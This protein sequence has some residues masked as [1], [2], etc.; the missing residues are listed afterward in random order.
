[1][2]HIFLGQENGPPIIHPINIP[3]PNTDVVY[4]VSPEG[5]CQSQATQTWDLPNGEKLKAQSMSGYWLVTLSRGN[6]ELDRAE[7]TTHQLH[8]S[9]VKLLCTGC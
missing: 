2:A 6:T 3:R 4:A 5:K 7:L 9:L 1:M 8:E